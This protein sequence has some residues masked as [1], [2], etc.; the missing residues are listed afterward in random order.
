MSAAV[1]A[2]IFIAILAN[3]PA[4]VAQVERVFRAFTVVN[5]KT[6]PLVVQRTTLAD[7]ACSVHGD[8]TC[9]N[10]RELARHDPRVF[11]GIVAESD[12]SDDR[13]SQGQR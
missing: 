5:G 11:F 13:V 3:V 12:A 8:R 9:R 7:G 6:V 2:G 10:P 1:A 4:V